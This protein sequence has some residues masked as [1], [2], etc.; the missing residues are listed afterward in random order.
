MDKELIK[1]VANWRK[2][3]EEYAH[4]FNNKDNIV[5]LKCVIEDIAL[6][7]SELIMDKI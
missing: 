3:L 2:I 5:I 4:M 6:F 7:E 1:R